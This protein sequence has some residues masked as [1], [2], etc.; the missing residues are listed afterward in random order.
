MP[1]PAL[2]A[3]PPR[4]RLPSTLH[5]SG[6]TLTTRP[7]LPTSLRYAPPSPQPH[8]HNTSLRHSHVTRRQIHSRGKILSC[9][10][11][12]RKGVFPLNS[13]QCELN[14]LARLFSVGGYLSKIVSGAKEEFISLESYKELAV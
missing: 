6:P 13:K 2:P 4:S 1:S 9:R 12:L 11:A 10:I 7:S 5:P 3:L 14:R 8:P